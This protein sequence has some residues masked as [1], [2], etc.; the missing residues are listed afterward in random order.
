MYKVIKHRTKTLFG[1]QM[2]AS[3][4]ETV[5]NQ[6]AV[7]GWDLDRVLMTQT[8]RFIISRKSVLLLIF[9]RADG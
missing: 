5:I 9:K 2:Q 6:H 1:G 7:D 4:L 8:Q 3:A